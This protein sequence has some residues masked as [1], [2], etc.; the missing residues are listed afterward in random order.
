MERCAVDH[1]TC[2]RLS[3]TAQKAI[4]KAKG[5]RGY[6]KLD[7]KEL[8][9]ICCKQG[10]ISMPENLQFQNVSMKKEKV[11]GL[12]DNE[13][14]KTMFKSFLKQAA[15]GEIK[16][17][18]GS[19]RRWCFAGAFPNKSG[20]Q[21]R[22]LIRD[23]GALSLAEDGKLDIKCIKKCLDLDSNYACAAKPGKPFYQ[24]DMSDVL[25]FGNYMK[26]IEATKK[27]FKS[28]KN[29]IELYWDTAEKIGKIGKNGWRGSCEKG[30]LSC[31]RVLAGNS[32]YGNDYLVMNIDYGCKKNKI[33]LDFVSESYKYDGRAYGVTEYDQP[34]YDI[35]T[36]EIEKSDGI[37]VPKDKV[38]Q[39]FGDQIRKLEAFPPKF[40]WKDKHFDV[41]TTFTFE[42]PSL[43]TGEDVD[44]LVQKIK[45]ARRTLGAYV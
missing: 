14:V 17:N 28:C 25:F 26:G 16:S 7:G 5:I 40:E 43:K 37:N 36:G 32:G 24:E 12:D 30:S 6:T 31:N 21:V 4:C 18:F 10:G 42:Y 35:D 19:K 1:K 44:D 2:K 29:D 11:S 8:E 20:Y 41:T 33:Y 39:I 22:N 34:R 45:Q 9:E 27:T 13:I 3:K 15:N 23:E 38:K